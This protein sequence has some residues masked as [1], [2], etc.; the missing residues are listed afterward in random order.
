MYE[1]QVT[2]EP[3][4]QVE[5][6]S[7]RTRSPVIAAPAPFL[8]Q[9][10]YRAKMLTLAYRRGCI[11]LEEPIWIEPTGG[12]AGSY[13]AVT[14]VTVVEQPAARPK[15]GAVD[16]ASVQRRIV[17]ATVGSCPDRETQWW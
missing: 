13:Q 7:A 1:K 15:L 4:Y 14:T 5:P 16:H 12:I 11:P 17:N 8:Q 9:D 2:D 10:T 3:V 6:G